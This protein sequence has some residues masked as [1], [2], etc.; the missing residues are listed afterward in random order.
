MRPPR[1]STKAA[2]TLPWARPRSNF[3]SCPSSFRFA[4]S[5]FCCRIILLAFVVWIWVR[6]IISR[7]IRLSFSSRSRYPRSLCDGTIRARPSGRSGCRDRF[8]LC[9]AAKDSHQSVYTMTTRQALRL[10]SMLCLCGTKRHLAWLCEAVEQHMMLLELSASIA[11]DDGQYRLLSNGSFF[12]CSLNV[13]QGTATMDYDLVE[14]G[15]ALLQRPAPHLC[16]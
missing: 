9:L 10:D 8:G 2:P 5:F 1:S 15:E 6:Y 11:A 16:L 7:E 3:A 13:A 12:R 4:V 14:K